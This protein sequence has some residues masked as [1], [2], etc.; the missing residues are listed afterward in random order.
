MK[1]WI[2][3]NKGKNWFGNML[4]TH[5]VSIEGKTIAYAQLCFYRKKDAVLYM[6]QEYKHDFYEV[7]GAELPES[8]TDNRVRKV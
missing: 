8:K 1:I 7:V 4:C 3:K 5:A 6:K 2:I